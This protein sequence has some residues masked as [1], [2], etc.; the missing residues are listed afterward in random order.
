[1]QARFA[2]FGQTAVLLGEQ[3]RPFKGSKDGGQGGGFDQEVE[4][5]PT[6]R[7]QR[8][9]AF[10]LAGEHDHLGIGCQA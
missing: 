10:V 3:L 2:G 4:R 1:V 9:G 6:H 5:A 8:G 7:L